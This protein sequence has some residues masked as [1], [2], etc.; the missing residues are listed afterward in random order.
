M[1]FL[2][3]S[4]ELLSIGLLLNDT[5]EVGLLAKPLRFQEQGQITKR[6]G[7]EEGVS[8]WYPVALPG[9]VAMGCIASKSSVLEPDGANQVCCVRNDRCLQHISIS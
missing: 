8:F 4:F 1:I 3:C 9:Y 5:L 2:A 7:M 6:S